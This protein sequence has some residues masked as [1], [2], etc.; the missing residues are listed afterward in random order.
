VA[1]CGNNTPLHIAAEKGHC[2]A[3]RA[4]FRGSVYIDVDAQNK[5]GDTP[6]TT[7]AREGNVEFVRCLMEYREHLSIPSRQWETAAARAADNGHFETVEFFIQQQQGR[8]R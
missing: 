7:A 4:L 2:D 5:F 8:S 1:G 3:A 6:M